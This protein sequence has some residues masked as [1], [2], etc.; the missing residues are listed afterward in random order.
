MWG[1]EKFQSVNIYTPLRLNKRKIVSLVKGSVLS[2]LSVSI[3]IECT[4][5]VKTKRNIY[6]YLKV[7][8][9]HGV[10]SY[11]FN[12]PVLCVFLS[13]ETPFKWKLLKLLATVSERKKKQS[14]D[15]REKDFSGYKSMFNLF[16]IKVTLTKL[17]LF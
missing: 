10:S 1:L 4:N 7:L 17:W 12:T 13:D 11:T 3:K 16:L 2:L 14:L 6:K 9:I 5:S 15:W 8:M